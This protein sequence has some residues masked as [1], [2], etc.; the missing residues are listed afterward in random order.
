MYEILGIEVGELKK[1]RT[2]LKG[3]LNATK[4]IC[5][6]LRIGADK[7][8]VM[9][10][11]KNVRKAGNSSNDV[12]DVKSE[13]LFSAGPDS[14]EFKVLNIVE[15]ILRDIERKSKQVKPTGGR[16]MSQT[17]FDAHQ[18]AHQQFVNEVHLNIALQNM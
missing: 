6:M 7:N 13:I 4:Q 16:P 9:Q 14:L 17:V 8:I 10:F 18:R 12:F 15:E 5:D 1:M 11:A 3:L 2:E